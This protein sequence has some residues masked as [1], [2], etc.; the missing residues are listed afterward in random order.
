MFQLIDS[1][2]LSFSELGCESC[3]I[4]IADFKFIFS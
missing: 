2:Q 1:S 4:Q 3:H